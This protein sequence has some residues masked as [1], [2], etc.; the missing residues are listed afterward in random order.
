MQDVHATVRLTWDEQKKNWLL[1]AYEKKNSALDNTTDTGETYERGMRNDTATP[2]ST[3]S[4]GKVTESSDT[5]QEKGEENVSAKEKS[6]ET[7]KPGLDENE[8]SKRLNP[9]WRK[10]LDALGKRI[11]KR[12]IVLDNAAFKFLKT[13]DVE[14]KFCPSQA[15]QLH[16]GCSYSKFLYAFSFFSTLGWKK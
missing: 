2:Q 7:E 13:K 11:G 4:T 15:F 16:H 14:E 6:G 12:I 10:T 3:V 9:V 1:T 8:F 5:L